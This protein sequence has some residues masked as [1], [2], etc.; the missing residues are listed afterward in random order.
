[1]V[2]SFLMRDRYEAHNE[3]AP[4][5]RN[6]AERDQLLDDLNALERTVDGI[7]HEARRPHAR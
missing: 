3:P 7:I 4:W 1:V 2:F 6:P 5:S